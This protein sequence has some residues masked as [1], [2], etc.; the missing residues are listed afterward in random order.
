MYPLAHIGTALILASLLYLPA[1]GL[2]VGVLLPDIVDKGFSLIG[3]LDCGRS[4]GHNIFFGL[5]VGA[6]AFIATR[7]KGLAIALTLGAMLHLVEDSNHFVPY[8]YPLVNYDF[9]SCGPVEFQPGTFE[10][11][12]E[13]VGIVLI[14]IWWKFKSKLF[15][16]RERILKARRLKRVFG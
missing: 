4:F 9:E 14:V 7:N 11:V 8:L 1:A 12:M 13:G 10:I 2:V 16:L 3:I 15:Y 5:G 6:V